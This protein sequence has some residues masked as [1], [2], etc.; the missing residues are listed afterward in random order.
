MFSLDFSTLTPAMFMQAGVIAV[1]TIL[2]FLLLFTLRDIILRSQSFAM[3]AFCVL[4]TGALPIVGFLIYLLI[5]PARTVK[6]REMED[7]LYELL[8]RPLTDEASYADDTTV[9]DIDTSS[10]SES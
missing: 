2:L 7:L 6:E 8:G 1:S 4:L 5:R 9:T 3:Q 10:P